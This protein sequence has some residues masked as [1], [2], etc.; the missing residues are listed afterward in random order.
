VV[1]LAV[2]AATGALIVPAPVSVP[3]VAAATTADTA[4]TMAAEILALMNHDR[5]LAGLRPYRPWPALAT[6]AGQRATTMAATRT[7]SHSVAGNIGTELTNA[8]IPWY[9]YGEIIGVTGFPWGTSAA[10]DL[11]ARWKA[12]PSHAAIMFSSTYNYMGVGIVLGS[13]GQTWSSILF[14]QSP[15]HTRPVARTTGLSR[16]GTTVTYSWRG[17]DPVLQTLTAGIRSYDVEYRIGNG[18]WRLIRSG[19]T[20]TRLRLYNRPHHRYYGFRVRTR[21][22][23]GNLSAWTAARRIWVP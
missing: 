9:A 14:T 12:S 21:D 22:R 4:A 23:R 16:S 19:T 20:A 13:D 15:D 11:Y 3:S 18:P 7:L 2:L 1:A 5:A 17:Y 10:D 6:L 8:R